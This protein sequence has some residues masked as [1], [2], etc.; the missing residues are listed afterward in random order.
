MITFKGLKV[1]ILGLTFK[2]GTD[3]L[4]EAPSK[5]NVKLLLESGADNIY[6]YDPVGVE[7]FKKLYPKEINYTISP[8]EALKDANI[9]FIF[10]EWNEIKNIKP[11]KYKELMK[12]PLI[13]DG[14]NIYNLQEMKKNGIEYYSIG[15]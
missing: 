10:T 5:D 6:A 13:Y 3:D 12:T 11:E 2:A 4:R 14:R 9:C 8:E 1:A 15:R 7:N